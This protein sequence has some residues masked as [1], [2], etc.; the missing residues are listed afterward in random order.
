M[1]QQNPFQIDRNIFKMRFSVKLTLRIIGLMVLTTVFTAFINKLLDR[2]LGMPTDGLGSGP[3]WVGLGFFFG[4]LFLYIF[5]NA[6]NINRQM[7]AQAVSVEVERIGSKRYV[8]CGY[9]PD[10]PPDHQSWSR[11]DRSPKDIAKVDERDTKN[12]PPIKYGKWQQNIRV[13]AALNGVERVYVISPNRD[14]FADFSAMIQRCFP[15]IT[16]EQIKIRST[17]DY[18]DFD[19][20]TKSIHAALD[21]IARDSNRKKREIEEQTVIDIT[22]GLK[23]FS[24]AGAVASLNNNLT[25]V[26]AR[27]VFDDQHKPGSVVAYDAT[28]NINKNILDSV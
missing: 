20:V 3:M 5:W 21:Q 9:S 7:G 15:D 16:V 23:T 24:I 17:G 10:Q 8:I 22:A 1:K 25:F 12:P 27:T 2:A 28:V 26:Y 18:E 14:Q 6:D 19:Y 11:D 13:L 4:I